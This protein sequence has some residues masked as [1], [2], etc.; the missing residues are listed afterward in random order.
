VSL[1]RKSPDLPPSPEEVRETDRQLDVLGGRYTEPI[2]ADE[3]AA[4]LVAWRD[5]A[6]A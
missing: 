1:F 3:V 6:G 2:P 4:M 5:E